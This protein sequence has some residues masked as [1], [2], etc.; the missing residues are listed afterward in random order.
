MSFAVR[1]CA[2]AGGGLFWALP[3]NGCHRVCTLRT[4]TVCKQAG[5][6]GALRRAQREEA[7]SRTAMARAAG[8][9]GRRTKG[10][11][12]GTVCQKT[13]P[14]W[15][16]QSPLVTTEHSMRQ[17]TPLR[18]QKP[19]HEV[20]ARPNA[21]CGG[22]AVPRARVVFCKSCLACTIQSALRS[23]NPEPGR[24]KSPRGSLPF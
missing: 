11:F 23:Q 20:P 14:C 10:H 6:G 12:W 9:P 18:A 22:T 17:A 2:K 3:A 4:T 21:V 7:E 8:C 24:P 1:L 15:C 5:C 19:P 16:G 13:Q